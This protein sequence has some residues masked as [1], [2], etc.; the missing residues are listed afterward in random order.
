MAE[1]TLTFDEL[2]E[3]GKAEAIASRPELTVREG[4]VSLAMLHASAAMA[5]ASLAVAAKLFRATFIDGAKGDDLTA[6]V[7]DHTGIQRKA[8]VAAQVE[9]TI[10]RS[11]GGA[12]GTIPIGT[13]FATEATPDQAQIVFTLDAALVVGAGNN[14][15][16]TAQVATCSTTGRSGNVK[17]GTIIKVVDQLFDTFTVTNPAQAAKGAEQ[18]SDEE[19]RQRA[20]TWW[21]TLRRGT[22]AALEDGA[23]LVPGVA[24]ARASEDHLGRVT[25]QVADQSGGSNTI[26]ESNVVAEL[27]NWRCAGIP[28][29]VRGGVAK[30]V[31]LSIGIKAQR[32]FDVAAAAQ[33]I[34]DAVEARVRKLQVGE[35]LYLAEI[36]AAAAGVSPDDIQ[37]VVVT[38]VTIDSVAQF[39]VTDVDPGVGYVVRPGTITVAELV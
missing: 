31:D 15:P 3:L 33:Y 26:M 2:V 32:G 19:L 22:F 18:E 1:Q 13:Q 16:F 14:G 11:S 25:V 4:D 29:T 10:A 30:I 24:I 12:G 23:R 28:L 9:L 27:E 37:N 36:I 20:R 39:Y 8:A 7:A 38:A 17:A 21:S 5:D 34:Q 6:L 35:I